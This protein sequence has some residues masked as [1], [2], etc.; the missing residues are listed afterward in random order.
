M[1]VKSG[2]SGDK[3]HLL[4]GLSGTESLIF[5]DG[6]FMKFSTQRPAYV[7]NFPLP[8]SS[9]M[10][11][12]AEP[13]GKMLK[14]DYVTSWLYLMPAAPTADTAMKPIRYLSQPTGAT[15]YGNGEVADQSHRQFL[16]FQ[17]TGSQI[18]STESNPFPLVPYT[19]YQSED[20]ETAA[21]IKE[22]EQKI[23]SPVRRSI[24]T[25]MKGNQPLEESLDSIYNAT[26]PNGQLAKLHDGS[27][28]K[29][30]LATSDPITSPLSDLSF[31]NVDGPLLQAL[32]TNQLF[33]V[34]TDNK[35]F[36]EK[37]PQ[38]TS[39]F[40]NKIT[41]GGWEFTIELGKDNTYMDYNNV[42]IMKGRNGQG[43]S[44]SELV[45]RPELWT[46][47]DDFNASFYRNPEEPLLESPSFSGDIAGLSKWLQD[48]LAEAKE[49][50]HIDAA[51]KHFN[52][53]ADNPNW[54]GTIVLKPSI[55]FPDQLS[56]LKRLMMAEGN[57]M[58]IYG[59]HF[60]IE[61]QPV[62]AKL[63][64]EA[65]SSIF[66]LVN[67]SHE[68]YQINSMKPVSGIS[69]T[70]DFR[71][72]HLKVAIQQGNIKEFVCLGQLT[73]NNWFSREIGGAES[74]RLASNAILL[75]GTTQ[76]EGGLRTYSL[77]TD[78]SFLFPIK[79]N[80]LANIRVDKVKYVSVKND[81]ANQKNR[82]LIS[83]ALVFHKIQLLGN[84]AFDILS[85]GKDGLLFYN[86][87]L[88]ITIPAETNTDLSYFMDI[89]KAKF[90]TSDKDKASTGLTLFDSISL[91]LMNFIVGEPGE[92]PLNR[93]YLPVTASKQFIGVTGLP[94]F[95]L[96]FKLRAGTLGG[97]SGN[98]PLELDFMLAWGGAPEKNESEDPDLYSLFIG[99]KLP[100]ADRRLTLQSVIQLEYS[101]I[102]LKY[103]SPE[104]TVLGGKRGFVL[105]LN[106]MAVKLLGLRLP[107]SG[108][109]SMYLF[110]GAEEQA[111]IGWYAAYNKKE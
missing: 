45:K 100:G 2:N 87:P 19:S 86:L 6:D 30:L 104:N 39:T 34:M 74:E 35:S 37:N 27:Y 93:G 63:K 111:P 70:Y 76:L 42:L 23:V 44:L 95:G 54:T 26:T 92:D 25:I 84:R 65:E 72:L 60:G 85:F 7:P 52:E 12:P 28:E 20:E 48:Y 51:Y 66:G 101:E 96:Q 78:S 17:D 16:G 1:S 29:V 110:G 67:L 103:H 82:L 9:T 108:N 91:E 8:K 15:L 56:E 106:Q 50:E 94:W 71:L 79:G 38:T 5:Q 109:V 75:K 18:D 81:D 36:K 89:K 68:S 77:E 64:P 59:H 14:D 102:V 13:P 46:Q 99:I 53:L 33:L 83:G 11:S 80:L 22:F 47:P 98:K 24:I 97:I 10:A 40:N 62:N 3:H 105:M 107:P 61:T 21:Q 58:P 41:V 49:L 90:T 32:Q 4:C 73:I 69:E 43:Q 55:G 57:D 31:T 88:D